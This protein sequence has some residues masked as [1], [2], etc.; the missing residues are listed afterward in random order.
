MSDLKLLQPQEVD[1]LYI[2]PAIRR[3]LSVEMKNLGIEQKKIAE[4]L[5]VTEAAVSQYLKSKRAA[6]VK[7][8]GKCLMAIKEAAARIK[9]TYSML[10]E[11]QALLKMID[12]CG[13]RCKIHKDVTSLPD[14]CVCRVE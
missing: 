3:E 8:D 9:D 12:D 5:S 6:K 14:D 13:L 11:T 7:F 2:L 10:K 4:R 1:V